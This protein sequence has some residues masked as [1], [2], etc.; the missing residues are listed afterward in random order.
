MNTQH[1]GVLI[2][3]EQ[4]HLTSNTAPSKPLQHQLQHQ[5]RTLFDPN[6]PNKPIYVTSSGNR[7]G[8]QNRYV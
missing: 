4:T 1:P 3:P 8:S 5:K 2:L 6:N 7:G